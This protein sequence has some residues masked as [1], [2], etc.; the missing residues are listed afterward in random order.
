MQKTGCPLPKQKKQTQPKQKQNNTPHRHKED[1]QWTK[2]KRETTL[3]ELGKPS[4]HSEPLHD[5]IE[6]FRK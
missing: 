4:E 2:W 3:S 6:I 5:D 1:I